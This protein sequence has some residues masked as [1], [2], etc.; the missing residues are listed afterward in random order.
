MEEVV[1][2]F[3]TTC[4]SLA[5][6]TDGE[7]KAKQLLFK[8]ATSIFKLADVDHSESLSVEELKSW[9]EAKPIFMNFLDVFQPKVKICN[10]P[11]I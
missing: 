9:V 6:M 8:A 2:I 5:I 1:Q 7:I 11:S 4:K 3:I 10:K